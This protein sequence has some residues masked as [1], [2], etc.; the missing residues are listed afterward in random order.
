MAASSSTSSSGGHWKYDV[1]L[2]FRGE[3]TRKSF[4]CHLYKA[5]EQKAIRT[6]IDSEKLKKGNQISELLNAIADSNISVVVL[7]QN[8]ATSA[9][10]LKEVVKIMECCDNDEK[11]QTVVPIFYEVDPSDVRKLKNKFGAAFTVYEGDPNLDV[12][13]VETWKA[14]LKRIAN[15][16]G[17]DSRQY[18]YVWLYQKGYSSSNH[19]YFFISSIHKP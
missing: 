16:S 19:L 11:K 3:D 15:L 4:V 12:K 7:S 8:Y 14:A 2:S 5:L 13:E 10:C 18:Q 17:W 6:F 1:F 9:W